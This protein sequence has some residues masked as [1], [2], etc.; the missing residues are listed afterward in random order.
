VKTIG[1]RRQRF[2][3]SFKPFASTT[4][5]ALV[6]HVGWW[7]RWLA[8]S[9]AS[10]RSRSSWLHVVTNP[11]SNIFGQSIP[12]VCNDGQAMGVLWRLLPPGTASKSASRCADRRNLNIAVVLT[13]YVQRTERHEMGAARSLSLTALFVPFCAKMQ[14]ASFLIA[15]GYPDPLRS[16]YPSIS[17]CKVCRASAG[18]TEARAASAGKGSGAGAGS[19]GGTCR[20]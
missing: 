18:E 7:Q 20:C 1:F 2:R 3:A 15:A 11:A 17:R 16:W 19:D 10:R 6:M 9:P 8:C 5:C 4:I 12:S 14:P 13:A